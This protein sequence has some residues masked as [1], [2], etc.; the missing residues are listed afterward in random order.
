M[1]A[2]EGHFEPA[3]AVPRPSGVAHESRRQGERQSQKVRSSFVSVILF[4]FC[5][6]FFFSVF[7]LLVFFL[8][9]W[10]VVFC[11]F[12]RIESQEKKRILANLVV[13]NK[14]LSQKM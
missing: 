10:F 2:S 11:C 12:F 14:I 4:I 13:E 6:V 9:F 8:L 3:A 7:V 5:F 1:A